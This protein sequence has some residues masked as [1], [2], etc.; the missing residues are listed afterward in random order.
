ML[1]KPR[2]ASAVRCGLDPGLVR[3]PDC[4]DTIF[5]LLEWTHQSDRGADL[6]RNI[7]KAFS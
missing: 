7:T 4:T 1:I 5:Y 6:C 3:N 2:T